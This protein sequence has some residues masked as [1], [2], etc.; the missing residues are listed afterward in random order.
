[1]D[2]EEILGYLSGRG[3]ILT[4]HFSSADAILINTCAFIEAARQESITTI[5]E[6]AASLDSKKPKII[7]AGCLVEVFGK[8]LLK[9]I[10]E[11]SGAIGVHS[12]HQIDYFMNKLFEGKRALVKHR[13][14]K[15][16]HPIASRILTTPV[17]NANLKIAD[18]CDNS[19]H[20]CMIPAIRGPYRSRA[21]EDIKRE[22]KELVAAG[23][24]EI[25]LV[26]QDTTAYGLDQ[27][28][29]P[30]LTG[31]LKEILR[32]PGSFRI[33]IMYTYPSRITDD[34]IELI[35][36]ENRICKYLDIPIQHCSD[37]ILAGMGRLYR[38]KDLKRLFRKLRR[39]IPGLALRT[40]VM[41]GF[42]GETNHHFKELLHFIAEQKF[43]NLGAFIYSDQEWAPAAE[44]NHK[45]P[46]R[47]AKKR[48]KT[49]MLEQKEISRANNQKYLGQRL[50]VL[51]GGKIPGDGNWYYGQTEYQAPEVDGLVYFP[52]SEIL[53]PGDWVSVV[54]KAVGPYNLLALH[55]VP[56]EYMP[57]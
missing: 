24:K 11:I 35:G 10:P 5:L 49:L 4:G 15:E 55:A 23:A 40:T 31:L 28:G 30:D 52:A 7:V 3:Y 6:T 19:C 45:V 54:I 13:P 18:G 20:Y 34:L 56:V 29:W 16:Y 42:P 32:I 50:P 2:T 14:S 21:P 8:S 38:K 37:D 51:V 41:V 22:V 26:A 17:H 53:K 1:M 47:I 12:Y 44:Y 9:K 57:R 39:R 27:K 33:R 43:E 36:K 46:A 48:Y 25:N